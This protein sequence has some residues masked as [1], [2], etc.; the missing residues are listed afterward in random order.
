MEKRI[1]VKATDIELVGVPIICDENNNLYVLEDKVKPQFNYISPNQYVHIK[2]SETQ[3]QDV[4][5]IH[6][7]IQPTEIVSSYCVV[8]GQLTKIDTLWR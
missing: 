7:I 5:I 6:E 3:Y 8:G 1:K 2:Y 4:Y